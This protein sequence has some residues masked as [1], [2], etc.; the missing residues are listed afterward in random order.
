LS[1]QGND[2]I[3][4]VKDNVR[5]ITENEIYNPRSFGLIGMRER[6]GYYDGILNITGRER[7]G[8]EVVAILP[9]KFHRGITENL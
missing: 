1:I 9:L 4:T 8:T 3:L 5:G 2:V 6:A 7:I